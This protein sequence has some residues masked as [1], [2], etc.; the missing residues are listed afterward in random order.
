MAPD[1][2][3]GGRAGIT[4]TFLTHSGKFLGSGVSTR[5]R[6]ELY[7]RGHEYESQGC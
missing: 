4:E 3:K 7:R 5:I 1:A 6:M 2:P